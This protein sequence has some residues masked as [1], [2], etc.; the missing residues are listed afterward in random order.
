MPYY[1]RASLISTLISFLHHYTNRNDYE[2]ILIEDIRNFESEEHHG[3]LLEIISDFKNRLNIKYIF[4]G[5]RSYNP[6]KKFNMGYVASAGQFIVITNPEVFHESNILLGLDKEFSIDPNLYIVCSCKNVQYENQIFNRFEDCN[7]RPGLPQWYQHSI[8]INRLYHFCS[9]MSREG[10]KRVGGFDERYC[11]GIAYDDDCFVARVKANGITIKP[12]DDLVT[13][14]IDHN[15]SYLEQNPALVE[16]NRSLWA[17]QSQT[18][19][20]FQKFI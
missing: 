5:L 14:H 10:Y 2:V 12:V 19:D 16:I 20:F 15:R 17:M 11:S 18:N 3:K 13:I 6:S 9:A 4:D 7:Y 8:E 1:K